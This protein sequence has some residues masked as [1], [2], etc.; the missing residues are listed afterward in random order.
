VGWRDLKE[1]VEIGIVE[2]E[3]IED[4]KGLTGGT[5]YNVG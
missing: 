4:H 5:D 1:A 2:T 3:D